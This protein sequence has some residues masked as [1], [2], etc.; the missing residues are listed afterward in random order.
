MTG[1]ADLLRHDGR[2]DGG[3]GAG[4][5]AAEAAAGI[6]ADDTTLAG[7][8]CSQR[9]RAGTVWAVLWVEQWTKTL[10]FCQ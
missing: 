9:A 10:P 2:D 3:D 5:L 4:D 6:F 8:I 7:S 1:R